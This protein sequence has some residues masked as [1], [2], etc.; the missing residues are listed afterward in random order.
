MIGKIIKILC[1]VYL[2]GSSKDH[3]T[4]PPSLENTYKSTVLRAK[5][6]QIFGGVGLPSQGGGGVRVGGQGWGGDGA[7][8]VLFF[9]PRGG[10]V[11]SSVPERLR[12]TCLCAPV[13]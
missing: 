4:L 9:F 2:K 10:A 3:F 6:F 12:P 13:N 7:V 1:L 11:G 8:V 5:V